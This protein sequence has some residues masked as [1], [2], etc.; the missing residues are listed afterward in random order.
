MSQ[1]TN[2]SQCTCQPELAIWEFYF[3]MPGVMDWHADLGSRSVL[4]VA[5]VAKA[6]RGMS[7]EAE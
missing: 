7:A 1:D 2:V 6:S 3:C 5:H 4:N